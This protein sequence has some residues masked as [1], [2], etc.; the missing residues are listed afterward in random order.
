MRAGSSPHWLRDSQRRARLEC[1]GSDDPSAASSDQC[2]G[3]GGRALDVTVREFVRWHARPWV[4]DSVDG[5]KQSFIPGLG[6]DMQVSLVTSSANATDAILGLA[7]QVRERVGERAIVAVGWPPAESRESSVL[8]W[9]VT[10]G[11]V[12]AAAREHGVVLSRANADDVVNVVDA[13]RKQRIKPY[14]RSEPLPAIAPRKSNPLSAAAASP[15]L[16]TIVGESFEELVV[17]S[18]KH[19]LLLF[20]GSTCDESS[21]C[22][23]LYTIFNDLADA[24]RS[25]DTITVAVINGDENDMPHAFKARN[26][27]PEIAFV[28]HYVGALPEWYALELVFEDLWRFTAQR[29]LSWEGSGTPVPKPRRSAP[30]S[31]A[32]KKKAGGRRRGHRGIDPRAIGRRQR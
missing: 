22:L 31:E 30:Y 17:K 16:V 32:A 11:A 7:R 3:E 14:V 9:G 18:G 8:P 26:S 19:T 29:L 28:N 5:S 6:G 25:D 15:N 21:E 27:F 2:S 1:D 12:R 13:V 24:F 10:I 20:T 4:S 23:M